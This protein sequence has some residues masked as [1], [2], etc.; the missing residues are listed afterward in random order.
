MSESLG[1]LETKRLVLL[2][3]Y[4]IEKS[5]TGPKVHSTIPEIQESVHLIS[6]DL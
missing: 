6:V 1:R 4:Q 5:C 2:R 3:W